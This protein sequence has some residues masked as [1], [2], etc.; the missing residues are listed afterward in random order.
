MIRFKTVRKLSKTSENL[1]EW[2]LHKFL[3]FFTH[4]K[5]LYTH[6]WG[7]IDENGVFQEF[8]PL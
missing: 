5:R 1:A 6:S 7:N 2:R 4:F 3:P 8:H